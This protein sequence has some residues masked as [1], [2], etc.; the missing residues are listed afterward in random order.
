MQ[1]L[2]PFVLHIFYPIAVTPSLELGHI[3]SQR[4]FSHLS[5]GTPG[6]IH[7]EVQTEALSIHVSRDLYTQEDIE[8]MYDEPRVRKKTARD[9][10]HVCVRNTFTCNVEKVLSILRWLASWLPILTELR[11]YKMKKLI[12]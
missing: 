12:G 9:I 5:I 1:P 11:F 8:V 6:L 7:R 4:R 2:C 3:E 10:V